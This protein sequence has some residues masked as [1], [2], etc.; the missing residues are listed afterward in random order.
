MTDISDVLQQLRGSGERVTVAR[1]AIIRVFHEATA[2]MTAAMILAALKKS[3]VT[4][5][6][7][8]VYREV[9]FLEAKNIIRAM[10]FDERNKRYERVPSDHRHHLICTGCKRIEDVVLNHD[11]DD[12]EKKVSAEKQFKIQRHAL[13]FYGLCGGCQ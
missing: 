8:T 3:G 11:L 1:R 2:P 13:E 10:Q 9:K 4:L 7:T 12:V 6:K 5:N